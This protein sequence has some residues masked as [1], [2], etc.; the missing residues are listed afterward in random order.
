MVPETVFGKI[1]GSLCSLSGVLVIALPV[2]VIVSNF[3]RIYLQTQR[4]DK[5]KAH[6]VEISY[7]KARTN[8]QV[9][10]G[11]LK[12]FNHNIIRVVAIKSYCHLPATVNRECIQKFICV[13]NRS[14]CQ[15]IKHILTATWKC[16][17]PIPVIC[18]T[19]Y[20]IPDRPYCILIR[21]WSCQREIAFSS[22]CQNVFKTCLINWQ[23]LRFQ[24]QTNVWMRSQLTVAC[25]C[26][27]EW[28]RI[29]LQHS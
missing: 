8:R 24:M 10:C 16:N 13:W 19:K 11:D 1:V 22:S 20:S 18:E 21:G 2:P 3:S 17:T 14:V 7:R 15:L 28:P 9:L 5:R 29:L 27:M 6:K 23:M 4:A 12:V 25:K 26:G